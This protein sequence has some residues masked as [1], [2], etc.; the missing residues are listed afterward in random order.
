MIGSGTFKYNI[1][2]SSSKVKINSVLALDSLDGKKVPSID[3]ISSK[4]NVVIDAL[5]TK[6]GISNVEFE[7]N[8]TDFVFKIQCDFSSLMELQDAVRSIVKEESKK[9][10]MPELDQD[11]L[12]YTDS[13]FVRSVPLIT[14]KKLSDIKSE[15]RDCLSKAHILL[16]LDLTQLLKH[17]VI[18]MA[19]FQRAK[20]QL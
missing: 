20:R 16:S 4:I 6:E 1:N 2:L 19:I 17:I 14:T 8:F 7:S 18:Q 10:V 9:R 3:E 11:W 12:S 5:K 15:D 13:K